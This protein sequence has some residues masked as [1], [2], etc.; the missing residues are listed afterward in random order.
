M[1]LVSIKSVDN[2]GGVVLRAGIIDGFIYGRVRRF[3]WF[4]FDGEWGR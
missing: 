4:I 2:S 1:Q 3:S